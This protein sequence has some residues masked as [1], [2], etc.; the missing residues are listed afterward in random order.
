MSEHRD[1]LSA[2]AMVPYRGYAT[3]GVNGKSDKSR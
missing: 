2:F 1:G 3:T